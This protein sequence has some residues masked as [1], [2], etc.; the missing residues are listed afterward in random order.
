MT[1]AHSVLQVSFGPFHNQPMG[2]APSPARRGASG[3][4]MKAAAIP[5]SKVFPTP[6]LGVVLHAH[7][8]LI[9]DLSAAAGTHER[10][11]I[12]AEILRRG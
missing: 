5:K 9:R 4:C 11:D 2:K 7:G 6:R 1:I 10:P 12:A 3:S 8:P